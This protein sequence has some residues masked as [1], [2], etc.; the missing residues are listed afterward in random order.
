MRATQGRWL[1][2]LLALYAGL[3]F[4]NPLMPGAVYFNSGVVTVV[5]G[6]RS[7]PER[8]PTAPPA[9]APGP[10]AVAPSPPTPAAALSA[11]Q[12]A[13]PW[14][15]PLRRPEPRAATAPPSAGEDH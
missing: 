7:T 5:D 15:I 4:A 6:A 8:L 10:H 2:A 9:P 12:V 1:V 3:D 13:R 14:R 11:A